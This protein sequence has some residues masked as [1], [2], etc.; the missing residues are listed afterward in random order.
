M[1]P[2][3]IALSNDEY[4]KLQREGLEKMIE[5]E[6]E[7]SDQQSVL[8][9][10][11]AGATDNRKSRAE[12]SEK[13][14]EAEAKRML[15]RKLQKQKQAKKMENKKLQRRKLNQCLQGSKQWKQQ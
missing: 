13:M 15:T 5:M 1:K 10:T 3:E 7:K 9:W 2:P 4:R 12:A 14:N 11:M 6:K 8:R